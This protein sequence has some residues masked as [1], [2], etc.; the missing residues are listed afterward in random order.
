MATIL[1]PVKSIAATISLIVSTHRPKN[2]YSSILRFYDYSKHYYIMMMYCVAMA[3]HTVTAILS[4]TSI[5]HMGTHW[6][7][8]VLCCNYL[9]IPTIISLRY[10]NPTNKTTLNLLSNT[11]YGI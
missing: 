1:F 8:Y 9:T 7:E 5:N 6:H 10:L 11:V 4:F 2:N 3:H